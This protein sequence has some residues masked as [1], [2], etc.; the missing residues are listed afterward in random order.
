LVSLTILAKVFP[1]EQIKQVLGETGKASIRE[2]KLPAMLMVYYVMALA[3]YN[4]TSCQ[5][6]L[7]HLLTA[8]NSACKCGDAVRKI[9]FCSLVENGTHVLFGTNLGRYDTGETTLA[10]SVVT[11]LCKGMLALADRNFF[12]YDLWKK[13]SAGGADLLWRVKKNMILPC[14][15]RLPDGSY[16]SMVY[17]STKASPD[18][19]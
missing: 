14:I 10:E 11:H 19:S 12:S 1:A 18:Y 7:G 4:H 6:L 9:R 17:P 15:K 5:D 3:L 2:R 8:V 16:L 13:A